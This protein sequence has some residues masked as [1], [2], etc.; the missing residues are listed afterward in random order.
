GGER[1]GVRGFEAYQ[2][3]LTPHPIPLPMGERANLSSRAFSFCYQAVMRNWSDSLLGRL[4]IGNTEP[5]P[6]ISGG[7]HS[8]RFLGSTVRTL[9]SQNGEVSATPWS[10]SG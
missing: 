7:N 10:W 9:D 5:S 3:T 4:H 8:R 1:V 6:I 2:E